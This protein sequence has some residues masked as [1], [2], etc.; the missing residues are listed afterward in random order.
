MSLELKP[1]AENIIKTIESDVLGRN[2]N[3]KNFVK[4][5]YAMNEQNIIS[6]NGDWGT[7]KTFFIKQ[8][9]EVI[10]CLSLEDY[11]IDERLSNFIKKIE[12]E[13]KEI[14]IKNQIFPIYYNAWEYDSNEDP[15]LTLIYSLIEQ[16]P[17]LSDND[18]PNQSMKE[19]I[20][21]IISSF[22]VGISFADNNTGKSV[23]L[24]L[25]CNPQKNAPITKD[26]ISI[27]GL[28]ETFNQLLDEVKVEKANKLV[29]F[30]D[31]LDRCNPQFAIKLLE[32]IKHFFD[33]DEFIFVFSTNLNELQYTVKKFYGEGI[34]GYLYLDK[35]FDLQFTLPNV[36]I[37]NYIN[38]LNIIYIDKSSYFDIC[39]REM[40]KIYNF[41]LRNCNRYIKLVSMTYN[42]IRNSNDYTLAKVILFPI[43][44]AI[45]MKDI[46]LYNEIISGNAE[47]EFKNIILKS[48][49]L[50]KIFNRYFKTEEKTD[51][52]TFDFSLF[53]KYIFN[54]TQEGWGEI[55]I[56][57]T[58][59]EYAQNSKTLFEML[60][61][62]NDFVV[63]Q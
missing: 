33:N 52:L 41:S 54:S 55:T 27:E 56:G 3:I 58:T 21:K 13:L 18:K 42:F 62:M 5:L 60:T 1:T 63:Y 30:I 43:L 34:D 17:N 7:G 44:L 50:I 32:R 61:F 26:V 6:L 40:A 51:E 36:N 15:L 2:N 23:G 53:Y 8:V 29:I 11:I 10:K 14:N 45:K 31:E 16:N 47:I 39:I 49:E 35:F 22:K 24:E 19:K 20:Y 4:I 37:E 9:V 46:V 12:E 57:K 38:S 28:K 25:Q 48:G 59:I